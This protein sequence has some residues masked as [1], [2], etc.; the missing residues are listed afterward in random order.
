MEEYRCAA[1]RLARDGHS[2]V[3]DWGCGYGQVSHLLHSLGIRVTALDYDPEVDGPQWR[4]L[5]R[6]PEL[7]A[8]YTGDP[9][10]LPF[11]D[12]VFDAVLSMGVLE[13][14][15]DPD[16]SLDEIARTLRPGG[17]L[18]VFKLPNRRSYLEAIA[19][20]TGQYFHG[21]LPNDRV[22]TVD[23]ARD[24][25]EGHGFN[26]LAAHRANMLPLTLQG[27]TATA[28]ASSIWS[29]NRALARVP[30]LNALATNVELVARVS[31]ARPSGSAR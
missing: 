31:N 23:T 11:E 15:V 21:Q 30:G 25:L 14:V 1:A 20:R 18:Y 2:E 16:G 12:N 24:L 4:P 8:L 6:Y 29:L 17:F 9:V 3:L 26:V 10:R 28:L 5:E 13:H 7:E 22:Y 19:R 27:R